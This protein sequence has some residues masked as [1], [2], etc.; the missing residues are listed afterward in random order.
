[1]KYLAIIL[2]ATLLLAGCNTAAPS[3]TTP[4]T[5][6]P[7]KQTKVEPVIKSGMD[8]GFPYTLTEVESC[9]NQTFSYDQIKTRPDG[10]K[11]GIDV[12]VYYDDKNKC[13]GMW[14]FDFIQGALLAEVRPDLDQASFTL[15]RQEGAD[16]FV[17]A[18]EITTGWVV[19]SHEG[20]QDAKWFGVLPAVKTK[21]GEVITVTFIDQTKTDKIT[22]RFDFSTPGQV[23]INEL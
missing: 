12:G 18:L 8:N 4:G 1:M 3:T 17:S 19:D 15:I 10:Q 20:G 23:T 16:I 21:V 2:S 22:L 6:A 14:S 13:L 11:G 5:N 7:R 9:K